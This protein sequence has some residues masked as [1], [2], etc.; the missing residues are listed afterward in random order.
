MKGMLHLAVAAFMLC[1]VVTAIAQP[2]DVV[3][4][5]TET[6]TQT[7]V[8]PEKVISKQDSE[9]LLVKEQN[10]MIKEFQ[11]SQQATVYWA[12]GSILG[13]VVILTGLSIFTNF[14][15]YDQDKERLRNEFETKIAAYRSEFNL[16]IEEYKREADQ[17]ADQKNQIIQDRF[18]SQ[19]S[20][21]RT[22]LENLRS[23]LISNIKT[24]DDN[25]KTLEGDVSKTARNLS[26]AE[27]ALRSVEVLVWELR[28]VPGNMLITHSQALSAAVRSES[29]YLVSHVLTQILDTL[30][31][32]YQIPGNPVGNV[33]YKL[34]DKSLTFADVLD[35]VGVTKVRQKLGEL[36][37]TPEEEAS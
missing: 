29:Q 24:T 21:L 34:L 28:K 37:I 19:T 4:P 36:I 18:L 5:K 1:S 14:K 20:E 35:S 10:R 7:L 31:K 8:A 9:L 30:E 15:L 26:E 25:V 22:S 32:Q 11:S 12:L 6:V 3:E 27:S 33:P 17:S 13:F 23:E 2:T 16:Q